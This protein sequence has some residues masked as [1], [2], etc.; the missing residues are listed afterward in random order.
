[1]IVTST[2]NVPFSPTE[3]LPAL[4]LDLLLVI[5]LLVSL[6]MDELHSCVLRQTLAKN[7]VTLA[8]T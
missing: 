6:L 3:S 1:M 5:L 4:G 7:H 8:L 2:P